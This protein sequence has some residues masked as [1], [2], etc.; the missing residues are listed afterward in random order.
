MD[1]LINFDK[2]SGIQKWGLGMIIKLYT[3]TLSYPDAA[4]AAAAGAPAIKGGPFLPPYKYMN[5]NKK[6]A[7]EAA[8]AG[9]PE[10]QLQ[11]QKHLDKIRENK[12]LLS[13]PLCTITG[14]FSQY[15]FYMT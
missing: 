8:Q 3:F 7:A 6:H 2:I 1:P 9:G 5:H 14:L 15:L 13:R 10:Q 12:L 11:Q 4:A